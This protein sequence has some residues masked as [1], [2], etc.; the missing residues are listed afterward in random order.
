[1]RGRSLGATVTYLDARPR[2]KS[3]DL[4][5]FTTTGWG[6]WHD[7]K[8]QAVRAATRSEYD[9]VGISW[10]FGGRVWVIESVKPVVRIVPLSS[11]LPAYWV[12]LPVD[13]TPDAE[14]YALSLVG[15]ARYSEWEAVKAFF[16]SN[17]RA[18]DRWQ[19]AEMAKAVLARCGL[20][21]TGRDTP[22][23]MVRGAQQ[24]GGAVVLLEKLP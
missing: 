3:G 18:D 21:I 24:L 10:V 1:M 11:L 17:N 5:A 16:G 13:W 4:L 19:C 8:S 15:I 22:T 2:I 23:D 12:H 9:H 20:T 14:E 6:T 7:W